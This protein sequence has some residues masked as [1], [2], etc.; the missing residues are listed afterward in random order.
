MEREQDNADLV[1]L[2]AASSD[3]LG[4]PVGNKPETIA[5]FPLGISD[6]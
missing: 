2:G 3:T 1:E 4:S 6:E 5:Y